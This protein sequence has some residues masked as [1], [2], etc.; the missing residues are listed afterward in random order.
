M[1]K[2]GL[3]AI[4]A[5]LAVFALVVTGCP[6]GDDG[7]GGGGT[8]TTVTIT[9]EVEAPSGLTF[10]G[11]VP[12]AQT[13]SNGAA[14][15]T[16]PSNL[17]VTDL[18]GGAT[19]DIAFLGW[20]KKSDNTVVTSSTTFSADTTVVGKFGE[21]VTIS[22]SYETNSAIA[23]LPAAP[24]DIKIG[25]GTS[26]GSQLP[27]GAVLNDSIDFVFDAWYDGAT[28][29]SGSTTFSANTALVGK[30]KADER[31][32]LTFTYSDDANTPS[33]IIKLEEDQS[34][35][36]AGKKLPPGKTKT[37]Y[38]F[39]Y[40][41]A[42]AAGSEV[43]IT[44]DTPFSVN[45]TITQKWYSTVLTPT[46]ALEKVWLNNTQ[47]AIYEFDLDD[48]SGGTL[49]IADIV[50][51]SADFK[52]SEAV[53]ETLT[54]RP[55]RPMGPYFYSDTPIQKG[56]ADYFYGDFVVDGNGAYA[57]K[58]DSDGTKGYTDFNKF[59]PFLLSSNQVHFD[60]NASEPA[61]KGWDVLDGY[62]SSGATVTNG[63][64]AA[65]DTWFNVKVKTSGYGWNDGTNSPARVKGFIDDDTTHKVLSA[66]TDFDKVYFGFGLA[67][68]TNPDNANKGHTA[69]VATDGVTTLVKSVTIH[70]SDG[71]TVVGTKP[72][73]KNR[74]RADIVDGVQA[75]APVDGTGTTDQVFAAYI[76]NIQY[77]WR[78]AANAAVAPPADPKFDY[79]PPPAVPPATAPKTL[80]TAAE[81]GLAK[82]GGETVPVTVTGLAVRVE[83]DSTTGMGF[84]FKLPAAVDGVEVGEAGYVDP[85]NAYSKITINYD[86][87]IDADD[88]NKAKLTIKCGQASFTPD[89]NTGVTY[90]QYWDLQ[91]G[92]GQSKELLTSGFSTGAMSPPGISFQLNNGSDPN[93]KFTFTITSI[94]LTP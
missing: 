65:P 91:D 80:S 64:Q 84:W 82:F 87:A 26:L 48:G 34:L 88:G 6:T 17:A 52:A 33:V 50:A 56:T 68:S 10:N 85:W 7:G 25:K 36:G 4:L 1:M 49:D 71:T 28:A 54:L 23:T 70:F 53:I 81:I 59:H 60:G 83:S 15:T 44:V 72:A 31:V 27:T 8:P 29:V 73:F 89:Y 20:F 42:G 38:Q 37:D 9:F 46:D 63:T 5:A 16:F 67:N 62:D 30:W 43:Q 11:T 12:Q 76:Y 79:V 18:S 3:Y 94:V 22:F 13:I 78:G 93:Q 75:T 90:A 40:W 61:R 21:A 35:D 77:N 51:I 66:D 74:T 92:A 24:L 41:Q 14:L 57:A 32:K 19:T 55:I 58:F 47:F 45:T 69:N 2:K 86:V 39:A